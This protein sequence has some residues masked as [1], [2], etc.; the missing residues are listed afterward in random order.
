M[1]QQFGNVT[2]VPMARADSAFSDSVG[3]FAPEA[4][5]MVYFAVSP[6]VTFKASFEKDF[7]CW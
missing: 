1:A 2:N 3:P 5:L 7:L 4:S 6:H